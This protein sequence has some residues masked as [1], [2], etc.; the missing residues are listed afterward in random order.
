MSSD[1]ALGLP[2]LTILFSTRDHN[3]L[4][5]S[6]SLKYSLH[7]NFL[8]SRGLKQ[9]SQILHNVKHCT[10]FELKLVKTGQCLLRLT[11]S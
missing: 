1:A 8:G 4:M 11:V 6:G 7:T 10:T 5:V 9:S 3:I 2:A